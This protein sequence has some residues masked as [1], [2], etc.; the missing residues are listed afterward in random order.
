MAE[1]PKDRGPRGRRVHGPYPRKTSFYQQD[2]DADRM[3]AAH[4]NT[5]EHTG[6]AT[7]SEFINAAVSEKTVRLERDFNDGEPWDPRPVGDVPAG[8]P[9][10]ALRSLAAVRSIQPSVKEQ[11]VTQERSPEL[12]E[13]VEKLRADPSTPGGRYDEIQV[14]WNEDGRSVMVSSHDFRDDV[15][16]MKL[17]SHP[18][19]WREIEVFSY[20]GLR[21]EQQADI[22]KPGS[23]GES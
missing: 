13:I 20:R 12:V 22:E 8:K 9:S 3:R 21:W 4:L 23:R 10:A 2:V 19:P 6:H 1:E 15:D 16:D 11:I 18:Q 5:Q 14:F 17:F 7:L